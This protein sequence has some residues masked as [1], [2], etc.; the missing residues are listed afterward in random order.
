MDYLVLR[1]YTQTSTFRI[2]EFQNFHKS[3]YLPPPTTIIGMAGAAMGLSAKGSQDFFDNI[4]TGLKLGITGVSNG[5]AKD[6]WKFQ[7]KKGKEVLTS[8]IKREILFNNVFMV[9]F[10]CGS[11]TINILKAAFENPVYGLTLGSSDS[12]AKIKIITE[13]KETQSL[14]VENCLLE[15]N[16]INDVLNNVDNGLEFSIYS[17][18]DPITYELPVKFSYESDYGIRRLVE[19]KMYSFVGRKMTLNMPKAGLLADGKFI[20]FITI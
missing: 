14:E 18:S 8:T 20:P 12:L 2:P 17:T 7:K 10:G 16:I 3:Y 11:E 1:I 9:A 19:R 15:G 5:K 4:K 13:W 6:L